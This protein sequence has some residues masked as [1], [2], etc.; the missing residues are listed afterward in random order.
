VEPRAD[1]FLIDL[2][3]TLMMM[4]VMCNIQIINATLNTKEEEVE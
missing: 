4:H 3:V 1:A 2:L